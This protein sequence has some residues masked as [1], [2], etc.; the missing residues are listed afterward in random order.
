MTKAPFDQSGS[1]ERP[2]ECAKDN[3]WDE[4]GDLVDARFISLLKLQSRRAS[5]EA[6]PQSET[7]F[8]K[9]VVSESQDYGNGLL[10]HAADRPHSVRKAG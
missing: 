2:D 1:M 8:R 7:R 9:P 6:S 3:W 10:F 5:Q 4:N